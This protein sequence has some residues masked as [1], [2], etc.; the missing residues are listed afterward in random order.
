MCVYECCMSGGMLVLLSVFIM[1]YNTPINPQ[2]SIGPVCGVAAPLAPRALSCGTSRRSCSPGLKFLPCP[3][4]PQLTGGSVWGIAHERRACHLCGLSSPWRLPPVLRY[5]PPQTGHISMVD[6]GRGAAVLSR[7][8][9]ILNPHQCL[10]LPLQTTSSLI[11]YLCHFKLIPSP[12]HA[13]LLPTT[14]PNILPRN[15]NPYLT[16]HG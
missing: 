1:N 8:A 11:H 6:A 14:H 5:R 16:Q 4:V 10:C 15:L 12:S 13:H 7:P 3:P 9:S 2:A